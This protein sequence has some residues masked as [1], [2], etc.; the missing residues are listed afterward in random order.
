MNL[1]SNSEPDPVEITVSRMNMFEDSFRQV[2]R[3]NLH[4]L[5]RRLYIQFRG[6]EGLYYG[7]VARYFFL[8]SIFVFVNRCFPIFKVID[9]WL[10]L[11]KFLN[12][13]VSLQRKSL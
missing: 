8:K 13:Q 5:R 4:D 6:E 10:K 3:E 2:M 9:N 12:I 7:G 11:R 1:Q